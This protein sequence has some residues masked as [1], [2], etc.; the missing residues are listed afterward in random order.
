VS[1]A[2]PFS[3]EPPGQV[4]PALVVLAAGRV[5]VVISNFIP[6]TPLLNVAFCKEG[7]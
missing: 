7:C 6:L 5:A 2:A 1:L 4:Q 3:R